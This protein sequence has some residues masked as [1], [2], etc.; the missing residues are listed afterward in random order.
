MLDYINLTGE[1]KATIQYVLEKMADEVVDGIN[2][3]CKDIELRIDI[4]QQ[5]DS[6]KSS[7]LIP[8][9]CQNTVNARELRMQL[10]KYYKKRFFKK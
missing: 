7:M 5:D 6:F 4:E 10:D 9:L 1:T 8:A 3:L 2:D